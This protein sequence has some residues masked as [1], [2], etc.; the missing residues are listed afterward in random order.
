VYRNKMTDWRRKVNHLSNGDRAAQREESTNWFFL[1]ALGGFLL[2]FWLLRLEV[3]NG[4]QYTDTVTRNV[5]NKSNARK[6]NT[7]FLAK[8]AS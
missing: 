7:R 1:F 5:N 4:K 2:K 3:G 8:L 6:E